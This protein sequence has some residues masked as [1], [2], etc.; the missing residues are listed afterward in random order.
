[1]PVIWQTPDLLIVSKSAFPNMPALCP[2]TKELPTLYRLML[3]GVSLSLL[4][5]TVMAVD[6][7][8]PPPVVEVIQ[9]Q[10]A[11]LPAAGMRALA[12]L[13]AAES[14]GVKPEVSGRVLSIDFKEGQRVRKGQRLVKL[15]DA[16]LVAELSGKQAALT[17]ADAELKRYELLL[18]DRQ[19]AD[20]D[21]ERKRAERALAKAALDLLQARLKQTD[22]RAPF[23]GIAGLRQFS[24]GEYVQAGQVLFTLSS[25][26]P[27]KA[28]I[29]LPE[30][31]AAD[32]AVQQRVRLSVDAIN[33]LSLP[34]RVTAVEP[35]LEG[36]AKAVWARVEV[37]GGDPRI[38]AGMTATAT[39]EAVH[40]KPVITVPEQAVVAQGGKTVVYKVIGGKAL[41]TPVSTG[42]R[43][44][45]RVTILQGLQA[46]DMVVVSGQNKLSRPEMPVKTVPYPEA[47]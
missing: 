39:F 44:A 7:P 9:V 29:K 15:D 47:R 10:P 14:V 30:A 38:R 11:A 12:T 21:V 34:G 33:G 6:K 42:T 26:S 32:L 20:L 36:S 4:P 24:P 31:R 3:L 41:M 46:G 19:V 1:M 13:R 37:S 27:L 17:L 23:D 8:R 40:A 2:L 45:S 35:Q 25:F 16:L 22:L 28:D 43:S 18:Q 5:V